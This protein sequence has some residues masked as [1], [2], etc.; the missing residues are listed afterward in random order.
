MEARETI[1]AA[2]DRLFAKTAGKLQVSYSDEELAAAKS[3]F[4]E[5]MAKILDALSDLPFEPLPEELLGLMEAA[6]DEVSPTQI[7]AQIASVPL[8]QHSQFLMQRLAHRAAEQSLLDSALEHADTTYG[9][10]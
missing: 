6:I 5:R 3:A 10:N 9:G 7:V 2:F 1:L 4:A 8:L